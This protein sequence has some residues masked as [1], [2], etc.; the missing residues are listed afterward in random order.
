MDKFLGR[1]KPPKQTQEET[2]YLNR[3]TTKKEIQSVILKLCT[4]RSTGTNGFKG[5][6]YQTFQELISV[7]TNSCKKRRGN[8]QNYLMTSITV[9]YQNQIKILQENNTSI[10]LMNIHKK[11]LS[12]VLAK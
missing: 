12:K 10:Y 7:F 9:Q 1:H 8:T 4:N 6:F 11:A 2:E 5:E 3:A